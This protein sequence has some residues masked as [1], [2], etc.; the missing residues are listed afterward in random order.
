MLTNVKSSKKKPRLDDTKNKLLSTCI[1]V[2]KTPVS[3]YAEKR[4]EVC[5]FS[6]RVAEK[7]RGF[8]KFKR[9]IAEKRINDV[10]F[11]LEIEDERAAVNIPNQTTQI[12][13]TYPT[14]PQTHHGSYVPG[15]WTQYL[16]NNN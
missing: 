16:S 3:S 14:T 5:H 6:M 11:D 2:L 13:G 10:L 7:L 9:A 4:E 1:E 15:A 8:S 12:P